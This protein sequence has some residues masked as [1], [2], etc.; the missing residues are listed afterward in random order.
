MYVCVSFR[1]RV[2]ICIYVL[3]MSALS[4]ALACA[5]LGE[6]ENMRMRMSGPD[7]VSPR[8]GNQYGL[9]QFLIICGLQFE[10]CPLSP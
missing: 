3:V 10:E 4:T 1:R 8:R 9:R 2:R 6:R 5:S 7:L